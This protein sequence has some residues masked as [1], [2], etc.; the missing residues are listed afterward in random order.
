MPEE[1]A[2]ALL[3]ECI[4]FS[5]WIVLLLHFCLFLKLNCGVFWNVDSALLNSKISEPSWTLLSSCCIIYIIFYWTLANRV[6]KKLISTL[7]LGKHVMQKLIQASEHLTLDTRKLKHQNYLFLPFL[8]LEILTAY[9]WIFFTNTLNYFT[10]CFHLVQ[11]K[12]YK[13]K[14]EKSC[15]F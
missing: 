1:V 13:S 2:V 5:S 4:C 7:C 12:P 10:S 3:C 11:T 6:A 14:H 15:L 9:Y 8:I